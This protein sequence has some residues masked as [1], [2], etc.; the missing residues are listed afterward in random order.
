MFLSIRSV[1][2]IGNHM[3]IQ[4]FIS[5]PTVYQFCVGF[6]IAWVLPIN[7]LT[8]LIWYLHFTICLDDQIS[9]YMLA[10]D[11]ADKE[12]K[13]FARKKIHFSAH[14]KLFFII[15]FLSHSFISR[16]HVINSLFSTYYI[17][18][19]YHFQ[20]KFFYSFPIMIKCCSSI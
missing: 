9:F 18:F 1:V 13:P 6:L 19:Y 5:S 11:F 16:L 3:T 7:L 15:F 12:L 17:R 8:N 10:K 4:L 2:C 20:V 14:N